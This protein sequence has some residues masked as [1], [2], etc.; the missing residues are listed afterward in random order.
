MAIFTWVHLQRP[1]PALDHRAHRPA[2]V[3]T[4][5]PPERSTDSI[6][7]GRITTVS[8]PGGKS[9]YH[10]AVGGSARPRGEVMTPISISVA[11]GPLL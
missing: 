8:G 9:T 6:T 5:S 2:R 11:A 1:P 4:P 10:Y 3:G 7:P